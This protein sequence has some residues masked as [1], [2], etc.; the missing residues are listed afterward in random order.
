M[1]VRK[2]L[3]QKNS[4]SSKTPAVLDIITTTALTPLGSINTGLA[5]LETAAIIETLGTA[6]I[7]KLSTVDTLTKITKPK[8]TAKSDTKVKKTIKSKT[9]KITKTTKDIKVKKKPKVT[10]IE[11][12]TGVA[13]VTGRNTIQETIKRLLGR[14]EN[15]AAFMAA[16]QGKTSDELLSIALDLTDTRKIISAQKKALAQSKE[17]K[18]LRRKAVDQDWKELLIAARAMVLCGLPYR[19]TDKKTL[20]K[21]SRLGSGQTLR[22]TY[23][24]QGDYPLPYG[25]DRAVLAVITTAASRQ[26]SPRVRFDSA[27]AFLDTFGLTDSG[28]NFKNLGNSINRLKSFSC[29]ISIDD[30]TYEQSNNGV[31][32]KRAGT[33]SQ[34]ALDQEQDWQNNPPIHPD[35]FYVELDPSFFQEI[36][37]HGIPIPLDLM[38]R[39]ANVPLA[40]D[41]IT[42]IN[43]RSKITN[44]PSRIAL[45]ALCMML[46]SN[47][48]NLRKIRMRLEVILDELREVWPECN[49]HFEGRGLK[50]T[51]CIDKPVNGRYLVMGRKVGN[52]HN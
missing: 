44:G 34:L 21:T 30:G 23:T 20:V 37:E 9:T 3:S 22:V 35:G 38:R 46:G 28:T 42:F 18:I 33:P 8:K 24:A 26:N 15:V 48:D 31:V 6:N 11:P 49:V 7:N 36:Q 14:K 2:S 40:W 19:K 25:K 47:D 4:C 5:T 29:Y 16:N 12:I 51:L 32:V 43:Y 52:D 41:F 1:A 50:A 17:L 10:E 45:E 39:Y 13:E 27:M